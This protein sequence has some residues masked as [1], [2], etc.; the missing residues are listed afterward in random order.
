MNLKMSA[1][2]TVATF[3]IG[4]NTTQARD[5]IDGSIILDDGRR[6]VRINV[7]DGAGSRNPMVARIRRLEAAVRDLQDSVYELQNSAPQE[8]RFNCVARTCRQSTS[9]HSASGNNCDFFNMWRQES[10]SVWA[11]GGADA[12][13]IATARLNSDRDVVRISGSVTCDY[14]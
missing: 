8:A 4:L 2:I 13:K 6:V 1:L 14:E 9:I 5:I 12:E 3:L 7:G 11:N 10:L